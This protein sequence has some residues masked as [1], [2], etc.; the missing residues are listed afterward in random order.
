MVESDIVGSLFPWDRAGID[1]EKD[2]GIGF[3]GWNDRG[4]KNIS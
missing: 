2:S 1:F 4:E 3:F